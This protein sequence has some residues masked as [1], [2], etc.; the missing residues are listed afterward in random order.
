MLTSDSPRPCVAPICTHRH[1]HDV[2]PPWTFE[3]VGWRGACGVFHG[4]AVLGAD[5]GLGADSVHSSHR[6]DLV[7]VGAQSGELR[8]LGNVGD[9]RD[10]GGAGGHGG[11]HGIARSGSDILTASAG[12]GRR[13]VGAATWNGAADAL[14]EAHH[15][16]FA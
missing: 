3:S 9:V 7:C 4:A 2:R 13:L 16:S 11:Q 1:R 15:A 5:V 14:D 6:S 8:D 12:A 10:I